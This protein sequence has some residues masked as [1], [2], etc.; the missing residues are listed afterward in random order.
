MQL[1]E[2]RRQAVVEHAEG[3]LDGGL[4]LG[5]RLQAV[6]QEVGQDRLEAQEAIAYLCGAQ[7]PPV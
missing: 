4:E 5:L 6:A 7:Q 1:V 3:G 2:L